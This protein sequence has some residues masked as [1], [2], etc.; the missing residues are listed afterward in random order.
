MK[1]GEKKNHPRT[2]LL[3]TMGGTISFSRDSIESASPLALTSSYLW[4]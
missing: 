1:G 4:S 2:S 3:F